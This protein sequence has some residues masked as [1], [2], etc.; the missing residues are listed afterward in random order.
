MI[1]KIEDS[2]YLRDIY[3]SLSLFLNQKG[4]ILDELTEHQQK[5][6]E[7]SISEVKKGNFT[8]NDQMKEEVK[9][10]LSK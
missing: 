3:D 5:R 4:D 2:D 10:W 9:K 7:V 8:T 6:I 1:D